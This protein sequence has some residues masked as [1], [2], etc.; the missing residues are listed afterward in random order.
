MR[1]PFPV[2]KAAF[3]TG[4]LIVAGAASAQPKG[5]NYDEAKVPQYEL[6]DPLVFNDGKPVKTRAD[7][8]RRRAEVLK[9]FRDHVYGHAPKLRGGLRVT[10]LSEGVALNGLAV[11][12]QV[13][14]QLTD[15]PYGPRFDLLI[16]RPNAATKPVP[17]VIG[18]NFNGNHSIHSDPAIRVTKSWVRKKKGSGAVDHRATEAGRG[19]SANRWAL[20][21]ILNRGY[22]LATIY[23]GDVEPDHKD[24]WQSSLRSYHLQPGRTAPAPTDWGA[25]AAWSA[26]LSRALDY[27]GT[28]RSINEKQVALIGHSRLGK[29]SLWAGASDERFALVISNN[30]GCGG[31]ALSRRAFGETVER[32]N[33]SFP[34][35]FNDRFNR[36]N[37]NEN[38][39]PV[40]QHMLISLIAPRPVYIASAEKDQWADPN[41]EFLSGKHAGP[42]YEL[43][44]KQG[45][46]V[47]TQPGLNQP[48]GDTI[49]YHYRTGGHDVTDY[50]WEQYL[51]FADRHF[52]PVKPAAPAVKQQTPVKN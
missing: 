27:L 46:G 31:A 11:R 43:L 40:D 13:R 1:F 21:K 8:G 30:S 14:I 42:V 28:D 34:H 41:G 17:A 29:T 23:Y 6:P 4:I 52:N 48:V 35:W 25:I 20:E 24:G 44:G 32:I 3:A 7:W 47:D 2:L 50:D 22:A 33:T 15:K 10:V 9:L 19:K 12:K 37:D 45:L 39:C 49:A 36:Y 16:Y 26:G 5:Y 38:A 18:Y 51:N